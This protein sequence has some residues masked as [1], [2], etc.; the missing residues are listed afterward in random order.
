MQTIQSQKI[1]GIFYHVL[2]KR[3]LVDGEQ[4]HVKWADGTE[5]L[6]TIKVASET[7][8]GGV[9]RHMAYLEVPHK[10]GVVIVGILG[11]EAERKT[12]RDQILKLQAKFDSAVE[13]V[14]KKVIAEAKTKKR[15]RRKSRKTRRV[16]K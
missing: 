12:Y 5:S 3:P 1:N 6:E 14:V 8:V 10:G 7:P 4:L 13:S 11:I 2:A 15:G 9:H 16:R